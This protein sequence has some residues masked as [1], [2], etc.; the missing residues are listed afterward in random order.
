MGVDML[1]RPLLL[2]L[3]VLLVQGCRTPASL[4]SPSEASTATAH[5]SRAP[6]DA[7][8]HAMAELMVENEALVEWQVARLAAACNRV[9]A[10]SER[11]AVRKE[12]LRLKAAYAT[13]SYAIVAGP[14][15]LVQVLDLLAM[16]AL[17]HQIWITEARS[18]QE[19][20]S[21]APEINSA[22]EGI[23]HHIRTHS[24]RYLSVDEIRQV[25]QTVRTWRQNHPGPAVSEF[26]RFDAF[27]K[28]LATTL[29]GGSTTERG[30]FARIRAATHDAQLLGERAIFLAS[31]IPRLTEWHAESAAANLLGHGEVSQAMT[32][33]QEL[34]TLQRIVPEQVNRI[35]GRLA[36]LPRE[37]AESLAARAE[38]SAALGQVEQAGRRVQ[39]L[40]S[41]VRILERSVTNLSHQLSQLATMTHP[42]QVREAADKSAAVVAAQ[43]RSL[44]WLAL[45]GGAAL[46]VLNFALKR[47]AEGRKSL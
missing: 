15:A 2:L 24:E 28:E 16:A 32:S 39:A 13:S 37:L 47:S 46:I 12:A 9:A 33:L 22:F 6:A 11:S 19:F 31:R 29:A 7:S 40:E 26:I 38:V 41:S 35:E 36:A 5:S 43:A 3:P 17:S 8:S 25:E 1:T 27:A 34:G 45:G 23:Q 42:D 14:N 30:L 20:G 44:L 21:H 18:T 10:A 4:S